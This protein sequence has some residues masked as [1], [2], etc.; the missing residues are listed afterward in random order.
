LNLCMRSLVTV[1]RLKLAKDE[2]AVDKKVCVCVCCFLRGSALYSPRALTC[3]CMCVMRLICVDESA[4][5]GGGQSACRGREAM[6]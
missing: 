5:T 6:G 1:C 4:S 3:L 2:E